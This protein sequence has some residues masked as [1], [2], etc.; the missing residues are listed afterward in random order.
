MEHQQGQARGRGGSKEPLK[1]GQTMLA[2][3]ARS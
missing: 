3:E 1:E 2:E